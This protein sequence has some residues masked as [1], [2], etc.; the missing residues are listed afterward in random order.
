MNIPDKI[1]IQGLEYRVEWVPV[2]S[3]GINRLLGEIRHTE[4]RIRL[5]AEQNQQRAAVT[6]WHEIVHAV[7]EQ[8]GLNLGD[9]EERV[10]DTMAFAVY[11]ILEDNVGRLWP[12]AGGAAA[13]GE[14][15]PQSAAPTAPFAQ[16]SQRCGGTPSVS[17]ADSFPRGEAEAPAGA[18]QPLSQPT[19]DSSPCRGASERRRGE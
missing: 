16:G 18:G 7:I 3:D 14:T 5:D 8:S 4:L 17:C 2:L 1:R 12:E 9:M 11:Q 15:I 19:A 13:A 6:L 10:A